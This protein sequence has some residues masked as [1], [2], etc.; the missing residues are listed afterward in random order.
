MLLY[1]FFLFFYL[2]KMITSCTL[3]RS[4]IIFGSKIR[5]L[6]YCNIEL[7]EFYFKQIPFD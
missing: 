3:V 2:K 5:I 7:Y 4:I 6:S 1:I